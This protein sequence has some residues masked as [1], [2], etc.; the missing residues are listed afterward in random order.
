MHEPFVGRA[1][2]VSRLCSLRMAFAVLG[3]Q[4]VMQTLHPLG[5]HL[6]LQK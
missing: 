3:Q 4:T 1:Y 5:A 2:R 6:P